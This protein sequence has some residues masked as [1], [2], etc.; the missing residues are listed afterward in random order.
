[1]LLLRLDLRL[2]SVV[3]TSVAAAVA[4]AG[5]A[6]DAALGGLLLQVFE[7]CLEFVGHNPL[8]WTAYLEWV[9]DFASLPP[10]LIR[11]RMD[12]AIQQAS[13]KP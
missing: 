5:G 1:M 13:H 4:T 7:R 6:V 8:V 12:Q 11:A 2:P 9:R 3:A 10:N